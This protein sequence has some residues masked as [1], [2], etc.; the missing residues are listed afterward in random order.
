MKLLLRPPRR[1]MDVKV[2]LQKLVR[3]TK[4]H[5]KTFGTVALYRQT[6]A[7]LWSVRGESCNYRVCSRFHGSVE[8]I[9]IGRTVL[10]FDK[11]VK[12]GTI[13]P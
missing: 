2:I 11:E 1:Y 12:D 3:L 13:V 9:Q 7:L 10:F 4:R 6:A 5:G 8:S